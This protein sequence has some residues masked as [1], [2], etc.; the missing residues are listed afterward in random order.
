M[1]TSL[2]FMERMGVVFLISA[3]LAVLIS[4][5]TPQKRGT[6]TIETGNVAYTTRAAFNAG[7]LAVILILIA[8]YRT[9]W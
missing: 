4:L 2:P 1:W 7:A 8:L 3:A 9:W 5:V 6:D